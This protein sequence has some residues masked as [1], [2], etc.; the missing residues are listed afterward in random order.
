MPKLLKFGLKVDSIYNE[1]G[2]YTN[3]G[4]RGAVM[5]THV[6]LS[7]SILRRSFTE[8][9]P[10]RL[11]KLQK[12]LFFTSYQYL[13]LT[14]EIPF[15]E[16]FICENHGPVSMSVALAFKEYGNGA[17]T[18]YGLEGGDVSYLA[19]EEKSPAIH[20]ALD[21]VW[22]KYKKCPAFFLS[23]ETHLWGS[24]WWRAKKRD[25]RNARITIND[26]QQGKWFTRIDSK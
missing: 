14:R 13:L 25:G 20:D 21:A 15:S 11:N 6:M 17:I 12:L 26:L 9:K 18:K 22:C 2:E 1:V 19:D 24:A 7:N 23:F 4:G 3:N 5:L 8:C 16:D 10:L